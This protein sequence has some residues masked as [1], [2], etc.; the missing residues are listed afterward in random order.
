MILEDNADLPDT[1]IMAPRTFI[2]IDKFTDST[3]QP[4]K[5]PPSLEGKSFLATSNVS[6]TETQ[7]T[8]SD[9]STIYFGGWRQMIIGMRQRL[10]IEVLKERYM[11][12]LQIGFIAHLRADIVLAQPKAFGRLIGIIP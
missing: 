9:A 11:D 12:T 1:M 6:I 5:R 7:G 8:A 10:R 4:I 2:T 3:T